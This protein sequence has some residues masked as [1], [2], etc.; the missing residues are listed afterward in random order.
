MRWCGTLVVLLILA[1]AAQAQAPLPVGPPTPATAEPPYDPVADGQDEA[2]L[3]EMLYGT[4]SAEEI[5]SSPS[6]WCALF[7]SS[8][9]LRIK[10][11]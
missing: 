8:L 9:T 4:F 6:L 5:Y 7:F 10:P 11:G 1:G 2:I 3:Q